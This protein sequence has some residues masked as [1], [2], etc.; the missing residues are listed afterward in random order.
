MQTEVYKTTMTTPITLTVPLTGAL[1]IGCVKAQKISCDATLARICGY[2]DDVNQFTAS[3]REACVA[4]GISDSEIGV[5]E[6]RAATA[7]VS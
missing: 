4:L 6:V 1:L 3:L 2:G 5:D 7:R